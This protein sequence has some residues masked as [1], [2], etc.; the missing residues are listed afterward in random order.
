MGLQWGRGRGGRDGIDKRGT[1]TEHCTLCSSALFLSPL[2]SQYLQTG[3]A[4]LI[5]MLANEV[6]LKEELSSCKS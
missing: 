4:I 1:C 3:R 2:T 6:L 5:T